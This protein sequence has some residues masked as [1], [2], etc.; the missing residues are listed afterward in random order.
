MKPKILQYHNRYRRLFKQKREK[1]GLS[2]SKL[3]RFNELKKEL[4][5]DKKSNNYESERS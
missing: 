1:D 5:Y 3:E 4:G 2:M